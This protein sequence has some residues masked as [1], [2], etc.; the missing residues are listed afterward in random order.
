MG[1]K[2]VGSIGIR[3]KAEEYIIQQIHNYT[4]QLSWR[5]NKQNYRGTNVEFMNFVQ[6]NGNQTRELFNGYKQFG[7]ADKI[8][9]LNEVN[10]M[11]PEHIH[12]NSFMYEPILD[13]DIVELHRLYHTIKNLI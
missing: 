8:K 7:D 5:K 3:H 4:G 11:T 1:N 9:I 2:I 6:N 13:M 10:I 12:V